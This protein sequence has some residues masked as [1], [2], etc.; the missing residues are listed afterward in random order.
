NILCFCCKSCHPKLERGLKLLSKNEKLETNSSPELDPKDFIIADKCGGIYGRLPGEIN[1]QQF[2][3]Q[4]CKNSYIY[5]LDH[6]ITITIDDC[7]DCTIVT[8]PI[9]TSF[10]IRDCRRCVLATACQQFRSRDC[11]DVVIFL[12]CTT[13]PI[14]ESCTKFTFGP[15]QC[16]YPGLEDHFT[17]AGLSI[18]NC[19]WSDVYDFTPDENT[20]SAHVSLLKSTDLM[21]KYILTPQRA[22]DHELENSKRENGDDSVSL[23]QPLMSVPLS[24]STDNSVVPFTIGNKSLNITLSQSTDQPIENQFY[25]SALIIIFPHE[26]A[27]QS[28]KIICDYLRKVNSCT[29]VRTR[30]SQ[31]S[32][33]E[34]AQISNCHSNSKIYKPG[35]VITIETSGP[36]NILDKLSGEIIS[37]TFLTVSSKLYIQI[38]TDSF[39]TTRKINLLNGLYRINMNI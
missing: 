34:I 31:F 12:A 7:L 16:S 38:I 33:H 22:L 8:G 19:N 32:E 4:N 35:N 21:D 36:S 27:I 26:E 20:E 37:G 29:I 14:I 5:L 28:A 10:F 2:L 3:I 9:R 25:K 23:L 1:G 6:S 11:H 39:E 17:K 13:E 18:F 30:C 15:Y 24:F